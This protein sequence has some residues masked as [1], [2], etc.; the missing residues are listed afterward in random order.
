MSDKFRNQYRIASARSS[1]WDY[2]QNGA[3]F[4]TICT[5]HREHFFGEIQHGIM[6]LSRT[7]VIADILW[8]QIPHRTP[9]VALGEFVVMPNHIHGILILDKPDDVTKNNNAGGNGD[10]HNNPVETL[11]A[12]SLPPPPSPS[13]AK[14]EQMA[15]ISPRSGTLPAIVRFY[16][17]AV[18]R[19]ANRLGLD[20]GWQSRFHDRIIRNHDEYQRIADYIMANRPAG[21]RIPFTEDENHVGIQSLR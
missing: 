11:P 20:H 13:S 10:S 9:H 12:T 15:A 19:H 1:W 7:G 16:K 3:Y 5:Q 8:H 17:S 4:V 14:N 21:R 18:T 6:H 2:G